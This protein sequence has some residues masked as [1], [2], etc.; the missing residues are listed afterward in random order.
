MTLRPLVR[1]TLAGLTL[2]LTCLATGCTTPA[3]VKPLVPKTPAA[4]PE[5]AVYQAYLWYVFHKIHSRWQTYLKETPLPAPGKKVTVT[6]VLSSAGQI[7]RIERVE[8]DAGTKAEEA[9]VT[10][11]TSSVPF[12]KWS[13]EMRDQLGDEQMLAITFNYQ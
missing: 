5:F 11:I 7:T 12:P 1:G 3:P 2:V 4:S 13:Q 10:A 6:F 9:C 8:G